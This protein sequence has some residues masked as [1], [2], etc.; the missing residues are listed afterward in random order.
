M[1]VVVRFLICGE[2]DVLESVFLRTEFDPETLVSLRDNK[3]NPAGIFL[4]SQLFVE[5]R[6]SITP[7]HS[8]SLISVPS[9]C[10]DC[11]RVSL[12]VVQA[13]QKHDHLQRSQ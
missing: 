11:T 13:S 3:N 6:A 12:C 10:I 1:V 4:S 7:D 2:I 9:S 5:S 8:G